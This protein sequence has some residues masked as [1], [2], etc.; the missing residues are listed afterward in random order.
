MRIVEVAFPIPLDRTFH[1]LI[2]DGISSLEP[3]MRVKAPFGTRKLT[4]FVVSIFEGEP[5]R[6]LKPIDEI[7]D[8]EPLL[9]L[10]GFNCARKR[11]FRFTER[12]KKKRGRSSF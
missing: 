3:G 10:E 11:K 9:D 7:L 2:G 1:Y 12:R 8:P 4:G 5:A 6:P